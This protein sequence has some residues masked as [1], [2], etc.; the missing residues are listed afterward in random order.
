MSVP[1]ATRSDHK[2][3]CTTEGWV[4]KHNARGKKGSHHLTFTLSLPDGR[5]L[6]TRIS[7]PPD[8]K[9]GYAP[10]TWKHILRDQLDVTEDQF[11]N[12]VKD[13]VLPPRCVPPPSN[14][15]IPVDLYRL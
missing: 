11:W 10:S 6:R 13:K 8:S 12:C 2:K 15:G 9:D 5:V 4:E 1:A 7:H 3:F 14:R